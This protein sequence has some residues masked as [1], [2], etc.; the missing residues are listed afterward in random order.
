MQ[1]IG[2]CLRSPPVGVWWVDGIGGGFAM[3]KRVC[4]VV[5]RKQKQTKTR[6]QTFG[7]NG[8]SFISFVVDLS[9]QCC[10]VL[11]VGVV[12]IRGEVFA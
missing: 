11:I 2:L 8:K 3:A 5:V 10:V 4:I 6:L 12:C 1:W 7:E 9:F